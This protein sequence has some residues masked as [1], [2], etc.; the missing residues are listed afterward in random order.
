SQDAEIIIRQVVLEKILNDKYEASDEDVEQRLEELKENAGDNYE[1][2]LQS[3]GLTEDELKDDL[4]LTILQ[5]QLFADGLDITDEEMEDFYEMMSEE[6][7]ASHI[8]VEDE[9]LANDL[10]KELEDG[11]DFAKLAKEHSIDPGTAEEGG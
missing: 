11:A 6:V 4:R 8:L 2:I 1:L 3:Q 7:E 10:I 5:E 9:E